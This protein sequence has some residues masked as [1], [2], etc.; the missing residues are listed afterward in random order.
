M[1][2]E[3]IHKVI[4][5]R[6]LRTLFQPIVDGS[7]RTLLG[8]EALTRGLVSGLESP[9]TLIECASRYGLT[10][11]LETACVETALGAFHALRIEGRLFLNLLPQT[12]LEWGTLADWLGEQLAAHR[13]DP[14][15]VVLEITEHGLTA[16]ENRLAAAV[17]PLR[18]LGC[19]IA[20][21]DLGAGSSGLKSWAEIRPDY[22]KVDRYFVSGIERDPVRAEILRSLVDIGRVTGCRIVAEGI[23]NREQCALVLEL[24]VDYLQGYYLGRP[25]RIPCTAP[26]A[27]E[28]LEAAGAAPAGNCAADLAL[29]IPGVPAE[30]T[31]ASVV[32][33]FCQHPD[34]TALAVLESRD[35]PRPVGLV[36]RDRLL[37]FLSRPLHP[38]IYNRK[39]VSSVMAREPLQVEAR[40]RLDQ[41]SRIVTARAAPH[42]RDD[43]I[44]SRNGAYLG[45]GRTVDLLRQI[46][47]QQIQAAMHSNPLTGLPGNLEIQ[48]QLAQWVARRRHFVACHLDL[49][50]FKPYNDEYGYARGDQVLLHVAQ[51]ITHSVRRPVDFVGHVGGD[52]FVFL[53]RSLDWTLRLTVMLEE[54]TVSLV[55]FHAAEH[56]AAG[57]FAGTDRDGGRRRFPL[58]G[59]SIGAVA[60]DGAQATSAERVLESLREMKS[61]AKS[62]GG[63]SCVLAS[64][65]RVEDLGG[66][67]RPAPDRVAGAPAAVTA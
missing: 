23:E 48:A 58:L 41:V 11:A 62:R 51:V 55:N 50:H 3:A 9:T 52:D 39:P 6:A 45:L 28:E 56:R 49:N 20:I 27:L 15:E 25:S 59:V 40:A 60:V 42:Q 63:S 30:S 33:T 8:H 65:G 14:H 26:P 34:W 24:G 12:L 5:E 17:R 54:L 1:Q 16:D 4:S 10:R 47:A 19:D 64:S 37:I 53:L 43:F 32:E 38:E 7:S 44:I 13:I 29:P 18:A 35:S 36:Y 21:D 61:L 22:V 67:H 57:G 2:E 46:T 31:V 66:Q